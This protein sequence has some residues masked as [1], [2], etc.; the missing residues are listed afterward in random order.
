MP[1]R[2]R[3]EHVG[4]QHDAVIHFYWHIPID[5]HAIANLAFGRIDIQCR[6]DNLIIVREI[7]AYKGARPA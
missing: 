3:A 5:P 6:H 7:L 2:D 4:A 1:G